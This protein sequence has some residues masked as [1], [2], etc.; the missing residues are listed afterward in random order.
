MKDKLA[1]AYMYVLRRFYAETMKKNGELYTK[2]S[3]VGI[4]FKN[5]EIL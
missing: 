4:R 5:C 2:P 1:N 3:L